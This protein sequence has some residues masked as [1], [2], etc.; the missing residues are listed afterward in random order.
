MVGGHQLPLQLVLD[1]IGMIVEPLEAHGVLTQVRLAIERPLPWTVGT[2]ERGFVTEPDTS[3]VVYDKLPRVFLIPT[4]V[5]DYNRDWAISFERGRVK[6]IYFVAETRG[7]MFLMKLREIE[8][9]KIDFRR[10]L[11]H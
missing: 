1:V 5:G 3:E 11:G 6:H 8:R 10:G 4:P 2:V 9:T 7:A